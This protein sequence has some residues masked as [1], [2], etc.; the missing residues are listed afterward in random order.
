MQTLREEMQQSNVDRL[1]LRKCVEELQ[2]QIRQLQ[3]DRQGQRDAKE[4]MEWERRQLLV[5]LD[6]L[7]RDGVAVGANNGG[8]VGVG[9][10][11]TTP[12]RHDEPVQQLRRSREAASPLAP[13][14]TADSHGVVPLSSPAPAV[15]PIDKVRW[16]EARLQAITSS[17][18]V[19]QPPHP[20]TTPNAGTSR[21][22]GPQ[23][24]TV[25]NASLACDI[26]NASPDINGGGFLGV[27]T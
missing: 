12:A 4:A 1:Y 6:R 9:A 14:G 24:R 3:Q 22:I 21:G 13:A 16:W 25:E 15:E 18:K 26:L 17:M 7:K 10:V 11:P 8:A 5:Q 19:S 23:Q 27:I 20:L 2:G